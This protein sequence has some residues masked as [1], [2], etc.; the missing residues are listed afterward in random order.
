MNFSY[1]QIIDTTTQILIATGLSTCFS[2]WTG[3]VGL[4]NS[5]I[6]LERVSLLFS[7][8]S[9]LTVSTC[10]SYP[11]STRSC[12]Q[13]TCRPAPSPKPDFGLC[14][15]A[16][17]T[18]HSQDKIHNNGRK[19]GNRQHRRTQSIIEPT[20]SPH[21]NALRPPME[22]EEGIQHRGHGNQSEQPGADLSDLVAEIEKADSE[23]AEDDGEVE[24]GEE[25]ALIG[26]ED[27][28]LDTDGQGD[29]LACEF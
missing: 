13:L 11:I 3:T 9:F 6:S 2:P 26:E 19:Q 28:W 5:D 29:A 24:P 27:F 21:P 7:W 15:T 12:F 10:Y 25:G 23:T 14:V 20:L 4:A 17:R 18:R 1:I 22:G 16:P 8:Y